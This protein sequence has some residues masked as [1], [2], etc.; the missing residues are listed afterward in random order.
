GGLG[1]YYLHYA[2]FGAC[3][4]IATPASTCR[5]V[6]NIDYFPNA[7]TVT[8][9]GTNVSAIA[10]G[11]APGANLA[12][13]DVYNG[14]TTNSLW[15]LTAMDAAID[16]QSIYNIVVM[17]MSLTDGTSNSSPCA[18]NVLSSAVANAA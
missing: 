12:M 17:T 4:A 10:L 18:G 1:A 7:S 15:I 16:M 6:Y 9:H 2:D 8:S 5:V 11:V 13:F 14:G 3:T